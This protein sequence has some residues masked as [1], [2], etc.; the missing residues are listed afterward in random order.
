MRYLQEVSELDELSIKQ[1]IIDD[2]LDAITKLLKDS[3]CL[4]IVLTPES[5]TN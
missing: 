1:E 4:K 2:S 5:T 3:G